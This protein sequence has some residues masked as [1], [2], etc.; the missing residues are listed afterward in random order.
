MSFTDLLRSARSSRVSTLH[1]FL[2]NYDPN[3]DRV[4]AFVEGE[5]DESF[6]R[7]QIQK[8]VP[9]QRMIY[10]YNCDGKQNVCE[11]YGELV[12]RYATCERVLFFLDKDVDDIVSAPWPADPRIFVTECYSIENYV[13]SR[14]SATRYFKD[15]VKIRRV[16]VDLDAVLAHFD[17]E[18]RNFHRLM[19]PIMAWIVIMK[20]AGCKVNLHD[21]K[22]S[23]LLD[24][25]DNGTRRKP[26][27][28]AIAYLIKVT[29]TTPGVATWRLLRSTGRELMR[30]PPK[31][32]TRGKFEAWW[33]VAFSQ[34]I[35]DGLMHVVGEA[36]GSI[37]IRSQLT[38]ST[39]IQLLS[40]GI[41]TP[42]RLDA[43]L[44]F[45]TNR[46]GTRPGNPGRGGGVFRGILSFLK[47]W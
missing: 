28:C 12:K 11:L 30:L 35:L 1:K 26:R 36:N 2:T 20:R 37:K 5:A 3:S 15:F 22:P 6:Y 8:Y 38:A 23:E 27:R 14:E 41:A 9:D 46:G 32:Y 42:A 31:S 4:F 16:D 17:E 24:V 13:V 44:A 19:L 40:G 25:T 34:C 7:A 33:F 21:V 18:L 47:H 45:H 29:Q 43:F 39:F 10:V